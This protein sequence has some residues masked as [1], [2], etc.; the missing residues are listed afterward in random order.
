MTAILR[1]ARINGPDVELNWGDGRPPATLP[2]MWLR[3]NCQSAASVHPDTKQ[4]LVDTFGISADIAARSIVV[5]EQGRVLKVEW[6]EGGHVSRFD[7]GFLSALR[8][9]PDVLPIALQ[10]WNR[11]AMA[12]GVPSVTHAAFMSDDAAVKEFL[13]HVARVGFCFVEG[14]PGTPEATKA[15]AARIA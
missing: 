3:D 2:L 7:A 14:V 10:T 1:E 15:V 12:G 8:F 5:E 11:E 4:R 13:E 6:A 9:N